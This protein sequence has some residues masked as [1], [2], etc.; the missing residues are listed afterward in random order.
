MEIEHIEISVRCPGDPSRIEKMEIRFGI[1]NG[2][3]IPAPCNG[4]NSA[5]GTK[6][7]MECA[8]AITSLFFK[9]PDT[10]VSQPVTPQLP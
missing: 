5:N 4:C 3:K 2:E 8:A 6:P 9:D 10:D 7:C 1:L